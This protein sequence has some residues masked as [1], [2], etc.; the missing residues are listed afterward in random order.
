MAD[1]PTAEA[2]SRKGKGTQAGSEAGL[3]RAVD[4]FQA[5]YGWPTRIE[6]SHLDADYGANTSGDAPY[7]VYEVSPVKA[8]GLPTDGETITPTRWIWT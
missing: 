3:Q 6:G 4:A 5:V 7:E 8:F 2:M 1:A